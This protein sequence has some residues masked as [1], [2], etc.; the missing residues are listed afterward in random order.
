MST[1]E[2]SCKKNALL[3]C[4]NQSGCRKCGWYGPEIRRRKALLK[5]NGLTVGKNG[6]KFLS[7]RKGDE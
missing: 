7:L 3:I 1:K 4:S 5:T 2:P 6:K